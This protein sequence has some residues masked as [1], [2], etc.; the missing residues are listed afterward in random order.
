MMTTK[1]LQSLKNVLQYILDWNSE[2]GT[3][4]DDIQILEE[5]YD[6]AADKESPKERGEDWHSQGDG[7]FST[8]DR[9]KWK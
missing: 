8:W 5:Y 3:I 4:H 7:E 6:Q 1:Q 2:E 9:D